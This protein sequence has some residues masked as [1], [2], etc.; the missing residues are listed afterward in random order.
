MYE[1]RGYFYRTSKRN[2]RVVHQYFGKGRIPLAM[3]LFEQDEREHRRREYERQKAERAAE[4]ALAG[5]VQDACDLVGLLMRA[6]LLAAGYHQHKR[7]WRKKRIMRTDMDTPDRPAHTSL[8]CTIADVRKLVERAQQGDQTAVA[9][10]RQHLPASDIIALGQGDLSQRLEQRLIRRVAGDNALYRAALEEQLREM[11]TSLA[12]PSPTPLENLL[13]DRIVLTW[14]H[15]HTAEYAYHTAE[16]MAIVQADFSERSISQCNRRH[17]DA[18]KALAQVRK[19]GVP[20][21]LINIAE[22]LVNQVKG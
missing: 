18:V 21:L 10:L 4:T 6:T 17:L 2:G 12:G 22:R 16:R 1:D 19:L 20:A 13:I 14:L 15:L 7:Q 9:T 5:E 8:P 3:A 11:R